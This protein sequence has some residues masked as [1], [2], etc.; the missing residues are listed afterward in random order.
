MGGDSAFRDLVHPA[1]TYLYFHP[2][3]FRAHHGDVQRFVTITFWNREPV[4]QTFRVRLIHIRYDRIDLPAFLLFFGR[5][6]FGIQNDTNSEQVIDTFKRSL[7]LLN[8]IPYRMYR[9]GASLNVERQSG[10]RDLLF[11]RFNEGGNIFVAGSFRLVQL[12]L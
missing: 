11:Y 10:F 5:V 1:G 6:R 7:L 9:L 4:P 3:P 8:L 12:I 2:F